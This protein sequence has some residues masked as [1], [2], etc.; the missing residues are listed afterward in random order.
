VEYVQNR[1]RQ[2]PP[3]VGGNPAP[4][5]LNPAGKPAGTDQ[6]RPEPTENRLKTAFSPEIYGREKHPIPPILL[7]LSNPGTEAC[8]HICVS[9]QV[10]RCGLAV[11]FYA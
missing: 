6:K 9:M 4:P 5:P 7:G 11:A 3:A 2:V 1:V 10:L 8:L